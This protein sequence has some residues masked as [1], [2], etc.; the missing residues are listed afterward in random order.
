MEPVGVWRQIE[1]TPEW[2]QEIV[3]EMTLPHRIIDTL[4]GDG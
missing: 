2:L 3:D 1:M 4:H